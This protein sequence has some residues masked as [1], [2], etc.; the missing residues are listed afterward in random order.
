MLPFE[1]TEGCAISEYDEIYVIGGTQNDE[2]F[3][4][5]TWFAPRENMQ[6]WDQGPNLIEGR[7]MMACTNLPIWDIGIITGGFN[8]N[9]ALKTT[10]IFENGRFKMGK[11][12]CII[13][14]FSIDE[15]LF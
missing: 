5:N 2:F 12:I 3:S 13:L 4:K 7:N 11:K 10:E 8:E 14:M 6:Y 15:I 9:G 1:F